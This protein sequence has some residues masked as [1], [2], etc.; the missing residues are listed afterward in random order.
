MNLSKLEKMWFPYPDD[1]AR[2]EIKHL[3]S[4]DLAEIEDQAN[5]E[6][7]EL[8]ESGVKARIDIKKKVK[9][10][11]TVCS[12]VVAWE[13]VNDSDGK[14]MECSPANKLRLCRELPQVEYIKLL[15]FIFDCREK[16][17]EQIKQQQEQAK[18]N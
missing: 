1:T 11:L 4:G 5:R 13:N 9:N 3:L 14:A 7:V 2:F 17:A 16:L 6:V 8:T 15:N 10:E 18:G 12:A